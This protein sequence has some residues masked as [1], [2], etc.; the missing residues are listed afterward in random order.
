MES[1]YK[2]MGTKMKGK[3]M[4]TAKMICELNDQVF[5]ECDE[6]FEKEVVSVFLN[7]IPNATKANILELMEYYFLQSITMFARHE[8]DEMMPHLSE[9]ESNYDIDSPKPTY[10]SEYI[11]I[12]GNLFLA[13]YIDFL[14]DYDDDY[15]QTDYPTNLSYYGNSK[16]EAWVYFRDNFF[17]KKR[18]DRTDEENDNHPDWFATFYFA[19]SWDK[20]EDWSGKNIVVA[21]TEKGKKYLNEILAPKFYEKYKD[22]EIYLDNEGN[23]IGSNADT[24]IKA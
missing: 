20:P 10:I 6:I 3:K 5:N 9:N 14:C 15:K 11:G 22:V 4:K 16:Y 13:G 8:S 7:A 2:R 21:V 19:T 12:V 17:Y 18:F 1:T 24:A 23:I